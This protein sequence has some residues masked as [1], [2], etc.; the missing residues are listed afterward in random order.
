LVKSKQKL[1][2]VY[3]IQLQMSKQTGV[4]SRI[5]SD[6]FTHLNYSKL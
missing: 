6:G 3:A 2:N 5:I 1:L 4:E